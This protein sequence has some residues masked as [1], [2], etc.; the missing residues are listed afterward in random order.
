MF[1]KTRTMCVLAGSALLAAL[2][3]AVGAPAEAAPGSALNIPWVAQTYGGLSVLPQQFQAGDC[4][5]QGLTEVGSPSKAWIELVAANSDP[6]GYWVSWRYSM[7]TDE[8]HIPTGDIW[9]ATFVFK[10]ASG[11]E[12]FR[13]SA[14]GPDMWHKAP[15]YTG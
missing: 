5:L 8:S 11:A 2:S 13:W 6:P 9:H 7:Y 1:T 15:S 10:N 3:G 14:N 4:H 12:L